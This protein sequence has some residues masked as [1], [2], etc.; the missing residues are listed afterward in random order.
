MEKSSQIA[1]KIVP[2]RHFLPLKVG[3]LIEVLLYDSRLQQ[4][5]NQISGTLQVLYLLE[6]NGLVGSPAS[7]TQL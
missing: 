6:L 5:L 4:T 2:L 3:S 1:W 7:E